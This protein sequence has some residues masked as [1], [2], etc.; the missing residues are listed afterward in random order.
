MRPFYLQYKFWAAVIAGI[1]SFGQSYGFW[2]AGIAGQISAVA[3]VLLG[4]LACLQDNVTAPHPAL[5][6]SPAPEAPKP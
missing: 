4:S 2:N 5:P 1:V 6:A 3:A